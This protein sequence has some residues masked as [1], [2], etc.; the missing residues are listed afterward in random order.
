MTNQGFEK[1]RYKGKEVLPALDDLDVDNSTQTAYYEHIYRTSFMSDYRRH[2][3]MQSG[4]WCW[5]QA[6]EYPMDAI[7]YLFGRLRR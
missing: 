2:A 5:K 7:R 1:I 6:R 4:N 3:C